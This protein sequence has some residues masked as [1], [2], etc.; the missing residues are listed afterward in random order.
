ML[1]RT[2]PVWLALAA[3]CSTVGAAHAARATVYPFSGLRL[4]PSTIAVEPSGALDVVGRSSEAL[5]RARPP[6]YVP[7]PFWLGTRN[8]N[9][10]AVAASADGSRWI[11]LWLPD[12]AGRDSV[13]R[14]KDGSVR[15]YPLPGRGLRR[16]TSVV[17]IAA[18]GAIW[19]NG[20]SRVGR[21]NPATGAVAEFAAD[22]PV[23]ALAAAPDGTM[24]AGLGDGRN[25]LHYDRTGRILARARYWSAPGPS[26]VASLAVSGPRVWF[27]GRGRI[28][29]YFDTVTGRA[30]TCPM[31]S[32]TE[33]RTAPGVV[34]SLGRAA[35]FVSP[36]GDV[37]RVAPECRQE[38]LRYDA[39]PTPPAA[40]VPAAGIDPHRKALW[41]IDLLDQHIIRLQLEA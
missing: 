9:P 14:V 17:V 40:Y 33:E 41:L 36:G 27:R 18:D 5:W 11:T 8:R 20:P 7:Q 1:K 29:G 21:L 32:Y 30:R 4:I 15:E 23:T 38:P 13:I 35:Y 34:I 39:G 2:A 6:R 24:W 22:R 25:L 19:F 10:S 31:R 12:E 26:E 16:H 3:T 37:S 28:F